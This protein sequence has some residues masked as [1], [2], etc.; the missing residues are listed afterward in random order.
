MAK[1]TG[2][3]PEVTSYAVWGKTSNKKNGGLPIIPSFMT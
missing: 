3:L 1:G 2:I